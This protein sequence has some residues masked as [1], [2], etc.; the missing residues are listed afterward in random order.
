LATASDDKTARIWQLPSRCKSL[1]DSAIAE[2]PAGVPRELSDAQRRQYFLQDQPAGV[3]MNFYAA[4]EPAIAWMVP[5]SSD[6]C[7]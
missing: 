7:E 2:A 4:I 5:A 3:L 1:I 6:K